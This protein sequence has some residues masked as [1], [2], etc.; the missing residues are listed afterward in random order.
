MAGTNALHICKSDTGA[1]KFVK[2]IFD[3]NDI[4]S[5]AKPNYN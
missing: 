1:F 3:N 4:L 5:E 2:V